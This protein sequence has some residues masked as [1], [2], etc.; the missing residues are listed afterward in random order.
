MLHQRETKIKFLPFERQMI[1]DLWDMKLE[2]LLFLVYFDMQGG[3]SAQP[4]DEETP[5]YSKFPFLHF[6]IVV[7]PTRGSVNCTMG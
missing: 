6:S 3:S 4:L 1:I 5:F 7:A 2:R